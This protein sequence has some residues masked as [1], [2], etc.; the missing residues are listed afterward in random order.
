MPQKKELKDIRTSLLTRGL[1]LAKAS[2][3]AGRL[4]AAQMLS[5]NDSNRPAWLNQVE[6]LIH[7]IGQLKGTAMKVGQTLSIYGEH[8][9][10]PELNELIKKLQQD[11]PPLTWS[12][13]EKVLLEE[14][15]SERL[16]G[17][18]INQTSIASASIGQVY[19]ARIRSSG[20]EVAL[21]VQYPGVD[22]AV[23]SD[24]K[25]LKFMLNMSDLVP[26]GP[27]MDQIF[28]EIQIGRAHV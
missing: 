4:T 19:R 10:P 26:R 18:E 2:L 28:I 16:E 23:E 7:E 14:L 27:R 9:L 8:L 6:Y 22:L 5:K 1:S 25:L 20:H 24:L 15:G 17:L 21:K 11:S 3:K 13:I 12:S